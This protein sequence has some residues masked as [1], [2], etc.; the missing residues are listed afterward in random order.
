MGVA[1]PA[2]DMPDNIVPADDMPDEPGESNPRAELVNRM[3]AQPKIGD[4]VV[5]QVHA[6]GSGL[7]HSVVGGYKGLGTLIATRDPNK[8]ADVVNEETAKTYQAPDSAVK[9]AMES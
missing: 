8:A 4:S 6:M 1:V 2:D 3:A 9:S 5:N 7:Y